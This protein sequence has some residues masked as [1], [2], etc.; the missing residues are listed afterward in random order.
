LEGAALSL[1]N[2]AGFLPKTDVHSRKTGKFS[3]LSADFVAA[4]SACLRSTTVSE[5]R[6]K[7]RWNF[8]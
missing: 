1:G 3:T 7:N 2:V 4:V 5:N 6:P 8:P